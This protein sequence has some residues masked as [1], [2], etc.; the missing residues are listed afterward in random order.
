MGMLGI[1]VRR[2]RNRNVYC[3]RDGHDAD[4]EESAMHSAQAGDDARRDALASQFGADSAQPSDAAATADKSA[5]HRRG[6]PVILQSPKA[7]LV[8]ELR[9]QGHLGECGAFFR[10]KELAWEVIGLCGGVNHT[11]H[12]VILSLHSSACLRLPLGAGQDDDLLQVLGSSGLAACAL[13]LPPAHADGE[14]R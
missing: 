10:G 13:A 9:R 6:S 12:E 3:K 2:R 14:G 7:A 4:L 11:R 1:D 5:Y 8:Q